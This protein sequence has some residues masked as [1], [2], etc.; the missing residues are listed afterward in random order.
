MLGQPFCAF[1]SPKNRA[2]YFRA[3]LLL[4]SVHVMYIHIL[5]GKVHV[6]WLK[7]GRGGRWEDKRLSGLVHE[8]R[9]GDGGLTTRSSSFLLQDDRMLIST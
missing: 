1:F 9:G 7:V 6:L 2:L 5:L 4:Y 3:F 8:V